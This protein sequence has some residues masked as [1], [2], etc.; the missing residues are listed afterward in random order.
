MR[1]VCHDRGIYLSNNEIKSS[2]E[3]ERNEIL[4]YVYFN[5]HKKEKIILFGAHLQMTLSVLPFLLSPRST[6][7]K[8]MRPICLGPST[9]NN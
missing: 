1:V 8:Q 4:T 5:A 2:V 6:H 9:K 7:R 3:C